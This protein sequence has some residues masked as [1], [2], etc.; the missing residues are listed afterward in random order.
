M[1]G[2]G[3]LDPAE[4]FD[5]KMEDMETRKERNGHEFERKSD[6]LIGEP[7]GKKRSVQIIWSF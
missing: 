7:G 2:G 5:E 4:V 1:S 3:L 6:I